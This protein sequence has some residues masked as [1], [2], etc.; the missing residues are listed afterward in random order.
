ME[1]KEIAIAIGGF[2]GGLIFNLFVKIMPT[3]IDLSKENHDLREK[4]R[5]LESELEDERDLR[6]KEHDE[7]VLNTRELKAAMDALMQRRRRDDPKDGLQID[8]EGI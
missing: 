5:E 8:S 2:L 7:K 6:E 3:Y 4:I 1:W